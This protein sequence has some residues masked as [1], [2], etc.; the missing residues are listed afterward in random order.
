M[1]FRKPANLDSVPVTTGVY[2]K[3]DSVTLKGTL[4]PYMDVSIASHVLTV[5]TADALE[6]FYVKSTTANLDLYTGEVVIMGTIENI[7][8]SIPIILV[9]SIS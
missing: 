2:V 6:Q 8:H 5:E 7:Y 1:L 9:E 4:Q 3:G